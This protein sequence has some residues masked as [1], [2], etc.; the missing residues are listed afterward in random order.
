MTPHQDAQQSH[1]IA[2]QKAADLTI[3]ILESKAGTT[4]IVPVAS[5]HLPGHEPPPHCQISKHP[6]FLIFLFSVL[7]IHS[8]V[9][10]F[11]SCLIKFL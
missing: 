7:R 2:Q 1:I 5:R 10:I 4:V 11:L 6:S 8:G 9:Q 3:A